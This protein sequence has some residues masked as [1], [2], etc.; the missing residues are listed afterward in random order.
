ML[1][2]SHSSSKSDEAQTADSKST[3]LRADYLPS[4]APPFSCIC[5]LHPYY[6]QNLLN[7]PDFRL[8]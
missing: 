6:D 4:A 5:A 7:Q 2:L 3:R 1:L 8:F